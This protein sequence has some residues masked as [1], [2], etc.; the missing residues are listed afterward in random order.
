M[1]GVLAWFAANAIGQ[2]LLI[3]CF[4]VIAGVVVGIVMGNRW[5]S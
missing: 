2:A 4:M 5:L 1:S 3:V